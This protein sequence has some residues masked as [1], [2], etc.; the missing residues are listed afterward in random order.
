MRLSGYT[1]AVVDVA[2]VVVVVVV[3][4]SCC[5][6]CSVFCC[7]DVSEVLTICVITIRC[8]GSLRSF[9]FLPMNGAVLRKAVV[10]CYRLFVCAKQTLARLFANKSPVQCGYLCQINT[11]LF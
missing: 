10:Q 6:N 4:V 9:R 2:S 1:G 11:D 8:G 7:L 5:C 3:V